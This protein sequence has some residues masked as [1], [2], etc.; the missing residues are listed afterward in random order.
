MSATAHDGV[1]HVAGSFEKESR[2]RMA[3]Y[4]HL[5]RNTPEFGLTLPGV[6]HHCQV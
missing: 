2:L 6:L 4:F 3:T 1:I 5:T